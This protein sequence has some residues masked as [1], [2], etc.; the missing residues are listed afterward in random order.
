MSR[1]VLKP[2]FRYV[3]SS[4]VRMT[5]RT[6]LV[7]WLLVAILPIVCAGVLF[8]RQASTTIT[9]RSEANLNQLLELE[10]RRIDE[11]L[12]TQQ[13]AVERAASRPQ[14][15]Q[16]LE[17]PEQQEALVPLPVVVG[18]E[19]NTIVRE[20][21]QIGAVRLLDRSGAGL[22]ESSTYSWEPATTD[23]AIQAMEQRKVLFGDAFRTSSG[24][25]RLGVAVPVI[26][27][28][29][30]VLG[31]LL[32][33]SRIA[34]IVDRVRKLEDFGATSEALIVQP[35][36]NGDGQA[37]TLRRFERDAA[38]SAIVPA[39][40]ETPSA[41]SL[42]TTE[43]RIVTEVD[44]R[45]ATTMAAIDQIERTGW[46]VVMKIDRAEAVAVA[47]DLN[48]FA[49]IAL[50]LTL[51]VVLFGWYRLMSPLGR[52]LRSSAE[53]AHRIAGGNYSARLGDTTGD[54]L[55]DLSREI[56]RLAQDL[57][58]DIAARELAEEQLWI[59]AHH[60]GLTGL[61][62][63]KHAQ[64]V[65]DSYRGPGDY[66]I[67]FL[68]VDGFKE[69][70]D[71]HGHGIGDEV[72]VALA[73][74]LEASV[75]A[76][77]LIARWGGDEF[78]VSLPGARSEGAEALAA[79]IGRR[80]REPIATRS[81][82]HVI[83]VSV[84]IGYSEPSLTGT[85]VILAA[86]ADMFRAKHNRRLDRT[87]SPATIRLVESALVENRVEAFLQPVLKIDESGHQQLA[88]AE[89]LVRIRGTDG[90]TIP[91]IEF[92]PALGVNQLARSIDI[93]VQDLAFAALGSW[94]RQG[95]VPD[96]FRVAL[97]M[98]AASVNDTEV[99]EC[100]AE[101]MER[102][103][104]R[105]EWVLIEIPETVETVEP[106]TLE[107]LRSLGVRLAIDDVGVAHS[108]LERM[109]DL[110]ADIAKLD[111][112]WIPD[113]ASVES[114]KLEVLERLVEQ[115]RSLGLDV[116]AEGVETEEQVTMLQALGVD[117]FQGYFFGRPVSSF[118]F[119]RTWCTNFDTSVTRTVV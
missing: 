48:R 58:A 59:Q 72:L 3:D 17:A 61:K 104:I 50:I 47:T 114:S 19:L 41:L 6:R 79:T 15:L 119:E 60:D 11:S 9:E 77:A 68:D 91:P 62:N 81:G 36:Q 111:R 75:P 87:V 70:N 5:I 106:K 89:A 64:D 93:R 14:I 45:G 35:R 66:A 21:P 25:D 46:G 80:F 37:I 92:L 97:N 85:E 20:I 51:A 22:A 83:G 67:L 65:I 13:A 32:T 63:R 30:S 99:I 90:S 4:N 42:G 29:G 88:G 74:R 12:D 53:A 115:C 27:E 94:H 116:I 43:P 102:H 54:E 82:Q 100:L 95:V 101:A 69:I 26:S 7:L 107:Q 34:A 38:F 24:D 118:D 109:V 1:F 8:A 31:A 18:R 44:Y 113:L 49:T 108:N 33:E 57:E 10:V 86:D 76:G 84:G 52:R 2:H 105:P 16:A 73:R 56:D 39:D 55:G 28:D 96:N 112:R 71:V 78:L 103:D 117:S 98:G 23:L 110:K 40:S